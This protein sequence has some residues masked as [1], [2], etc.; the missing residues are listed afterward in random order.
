MTSLNQEKITQELAGY[1][2]AL[3]STEQEITPSTSLK[4][5]NID[6]IS[7]V[8][9]FVFVERNFKISLINA[10]LGKKDIETLGSLVNHVSEQLP[11]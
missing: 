3:T 6:S 1:I 10:G 4:D 5:L 8:K 2:K 11:K 9:I 7:L